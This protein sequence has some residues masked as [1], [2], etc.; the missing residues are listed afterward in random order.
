MA[1]ALTGTVGRLLKVKNDYRLILSITLLQRS[2]A[3]DVDRDSVIPV[4]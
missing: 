4:P 2:V 3:V 1:G